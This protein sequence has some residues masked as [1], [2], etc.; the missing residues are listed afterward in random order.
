MNQAQHSIERVTTPDLD[1]LLPL[2]RTYCDFYEVS[3]AD[4]DLLALA[5]ALIADPDREGIQLIARGRDGH[6]T[7]FAT[8][9]WMWSTSDAARLG[10]MN[11]LFVTEQARGRGLAE[12]LIEACRAEAASRGARRLTWQTAIDNV[13]AQTVYERLGATRE[14]WVDYWLAC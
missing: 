2:M 4:D 10:V 8:V 6:G 12:Q 9:Y 1:D 13:R 7:G 3:P 11:D 5:A 14:Q